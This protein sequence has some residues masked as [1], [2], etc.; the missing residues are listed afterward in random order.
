MNNEAGEI[1]LQSAIPVCVAQ[2][3]RANLQYEWLIARS[4]FKLE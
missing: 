1:N 3:G 4:L 2:P